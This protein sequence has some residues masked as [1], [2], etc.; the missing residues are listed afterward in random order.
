M[1]PLVESIRSLPPGS[2]A[3]HVGVSEIH[4]MHDL[5]EEKKQ[6]LSNVFMAAY[7]YAAKR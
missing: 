2:C 7:L 5:D 6:A 1:H 4:K 3:P